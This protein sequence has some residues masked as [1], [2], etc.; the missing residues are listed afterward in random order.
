[1]GATFVEGGDF[2]VM[3]ADHI[4]NVVAI[5]TGV[6][7]SKLS[8]SDTDKLL[9]LPEILHQRIIGQQEAIDG[10]TRAVRQS[11]AGLTDP[12]RPIASFIFAGPTGVGKTELT[13]A[14]TSFLFDSEDRMIRLDMSEYMEKHS[15]SRMIGSPPGYIGYDEGGQL[16]EAVRRHPYSVLLFDEIE[17]AHPDVFNL[18]LQVLDDGRLTDARGRLVDFKNCLIIMTTNVGSKAIQG[19]NAPMGFDFTGAEEKDEASYRHMVGTVQE[20]LKKFFRPEFLNRVDE[21]VV[22]RQLTRAEIRVVIDLLMVQ[23]SKLLAP[24]G[25]TLALS[26]A[27]K[28]KVLEEGYNPSYG[29]RSLRRAI[30]RLVRAPLSDELLAGTFSSGTHIIADMVDGKVAFLPDTA[31]APAVLDSAS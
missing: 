7:V 3:T 11:R 17:K 4:A 20:E 26:D 29:A 8:E 2:P 31:K 16:T 28:D 24:R 18:L 19:G 1:V 13:K 9:R 22:F 15:V 25:L 5:W 10:V 23:F 6:P 12:N 27:C 21:I 30:D 14:L